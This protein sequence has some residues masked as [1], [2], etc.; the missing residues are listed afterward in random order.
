MR[1]IWQLRSEIRAKTLKSQVLGST[2]L[3]SCPSA[4]ILVFERSNRS[5]SFRS[6]C[7]T[8]YFSLAIFG[9]FLAGR[10]SPFSCSLRDAEIQ[11]EL[12]IGSEMELSKQVFEQKS[13]LEITF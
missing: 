5:R 3:V 10:V 1:S 12:E 7:I 4:A 6:L 11:T 13:Q 9:W 8:L 2:L